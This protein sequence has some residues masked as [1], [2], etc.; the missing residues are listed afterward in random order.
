MTMTKNE[1]LEYMRSLVSTK[2]EEK[3]EAT[4]EENGLELL[5]SYQEQLEAVKN[6][7]LKGLV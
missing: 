3:K 4:P 6:D 1:R 7:I 5:L 2:E